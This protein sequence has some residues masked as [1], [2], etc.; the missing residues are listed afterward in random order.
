MT[1][2]V[3]LNRLSIDG[4]HT[5]APEIVTYLRAQA[6][7]DGTVPGTTIERLL[8][9]GIVALGQVRSGNPRAAATATGPAPREMPPP[10]G[11]LLVPPISNDGV[12]LDAVIQGIEDFLIDGALH[13]SRGN[14]QAAARLL[15]LKRTTLVAKL[16]RRNM[17]GDESDQSW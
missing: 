3:D 5:E 17:A 6:A 10:P 16:R 8:V 2:H 7:G 15:G 1:V 12:E 14:R 9:A 4:W 13:H 11:A